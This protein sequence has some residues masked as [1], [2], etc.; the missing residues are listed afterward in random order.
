MRGAL[1]VSFL[2]TA[3]WCHASDPDSTA[4]NKLNS[5]AYR[6]FLY[7]PDSAI[8]IANQAITAAEKGKY[9][10]QIAY[11]Y[12]VVSKANW[13]KANY[14]LSIQYGFKALRIYENTDRIFNWGECHLSLARTFADLRNYGLSKTYIEKA[15]SLARRHDDVHLLAEVYRE[16]SFLLIGQNQYDS[17]LYYSNEG[18][19]LF[20]KRKDTLNASILYGRN[21]RIYLNLRN[22]KK[23]IEFDKKAILMDS[24]S[25]NR[26]ALGISYYL[27]AEIY[28]DLNKKDSALIFLK[29][30]IPLN[31]QIRNLPNMIRTHG[32]VATIYREKG[33]LA[34]AIQHLQLVDQYKDSLYN[35]ERSGQ[36]EEILAR[37]G[38]EGKEKKIESL[39]NENV[40]E[41]QRAINQ[42]NFSIF[43]GTVILLLA[44]ISFVFWRMREFQAKANQAL[45]E[46][47]QDIALQHEEIQSQAE[48]LHEINNLKSKLFSVISHDLR[49][50]I[51][52]LHSL[53]D[54]LTK[55]QLTPE[56]FRNVSSKLKSSLNVSQR[57]LENLLNWSLSQMEGIRTEKT[58]FNISSVVAEVLTLN[59]ETAIKKQVSLNNELKGTY[60]VEADVNQVHL[61]L[62]NLLHNAIKFS[63]RHGEVKLRAEKRDRFCCIS[64]QDSGVGISAAEKETILKSHEYFTKSGTDREKGT[65]LGLH[66]CKDFIK[67]NGGDLFIESEEGRGTVVTIQLPL[68]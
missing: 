67:R 64:I 24:L 9:T 48:T 46:R 11:G 33:L 56:E 55:E 15:F 68:A 61:I 63:Q 22:Y 47:N 3:C 62:R 10:Y 21:V 51:N 20:E 49:G 66:L 44:L 41:K 4:V 18:I 23:S 30:S 8:L 5:K 36:I 25:G 57:T 2:L 7:K 27:A 28:Y 53:L 42:R 31:L 58:I 13:A 59:E 14:L 65:G 38:L 12:F 17:A 60:L 16:K 45:A 19:K 43:L 6:Y 34:L 26:R 39:E 52:N 35:L 32:L 29:K 50:P 40:L 37:F 1:A 54:L